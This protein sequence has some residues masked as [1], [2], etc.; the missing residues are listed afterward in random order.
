V[1]VDGCSNTEI[2]TRFGI[3]EKTVKH[4]LTNIFDKVGVSNRLELALFALYHRLVPGDAA[5]G[6]D[7]GATRPDREGPARV[8]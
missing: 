3:S 8:S 4:H 1:I 5:A 2:A 6:A 7:A